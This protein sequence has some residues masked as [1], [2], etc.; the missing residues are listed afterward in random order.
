[1]LKNLEI[2][3]GELSLKFDPLNT[4]YTVFVNNDETDLKL[5]YQ[6]EESD[7]ILIQGN[8]LVDNYNEVVIT[9]FNAEESMS[10]YLYVYKND[11]SVI[12]IE[13]NYFNKLETD[14]NEEIS[15]YAVP[16]ISCIC[17]LIIII[18]FV[19]LFHKKQKV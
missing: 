3:N 8:E 11:E 5:K 9:V 15:S 6:K 19:I 7:N 4:K 14:V 12:N 16:V 2:L 18:V 17:F 10:Y 1:M 13:N